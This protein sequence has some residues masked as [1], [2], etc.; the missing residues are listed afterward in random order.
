MTIAIKLS[1]GFC[2]PGTRV[3]YIPGIIMPCPVLSFCRCKDEYYYWG[4]G[5]LTAG[6]VVRHIFREYMPHRFNTELF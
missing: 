3:H 4:D 2:T 6:I 1:T 5:K